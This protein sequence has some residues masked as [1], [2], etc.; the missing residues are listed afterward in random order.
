MLQKFQE[1][2]LSS[3]PGKNVPAE[4]GTLH[5]SRGVY[6]THLNPPKHFWNT[7]DLTSVAP[8][9]PLV[10]WWLFSVNHLPSFILHH[11]L[12]SL[13][14]KQC[15]PLWMASPRLLAKEKP[16][17]RSLVGREWGQSSFSFTLQ[18]QCLASW[19]SYVPPELKI[20]TRKSLLLGSSSCLLHV[21]TFPLLTFST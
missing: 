18:L 13:V 17:R 3:Q 6:A 11:S 14:P 1:G 9:L 15:G 5:A 12:S 4:P 19:S 7:A 2:S 8:S 20:H 16:R 10:V 21:L